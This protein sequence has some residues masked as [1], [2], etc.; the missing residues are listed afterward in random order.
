MPNLNCKAF[1][2]KVERTGLRGISDDPGVARTKLKLDMPPKA[3]GELIKECI[4]KKLLVEV[5]DCSDPSSARH[6]IVAPKHARAAR[7]RVRGVPTAR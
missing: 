7:K 1:A 5:P 6:R 4:D 3:V 2:Q